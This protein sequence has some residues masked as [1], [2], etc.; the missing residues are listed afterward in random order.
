MK[1]RRGPLRKFEYDY[2]L[3]NIVISINTFLKCDIE[4]IGI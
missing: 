1:D 4:A 2:I 3:D